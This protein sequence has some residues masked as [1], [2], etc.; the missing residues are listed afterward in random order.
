MDPRRQTSQL[1]LELDSQ[2]ASSMTHPEAPGW[3]QGRPSKDQKVGNGPIP[4]NLY[5]FPQIVEIIP[6]SA[7][8]ITQPIKTNHAT[9][10]GH[11]TRLL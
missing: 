2:S 7:Y 1:P 6:H 5:P 10:Q 8:E 4:G 9:F 11:R 3:F